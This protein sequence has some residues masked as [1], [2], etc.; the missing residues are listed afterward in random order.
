MTNQ[1]SAKTDQ[2]D[3]I[4]LACKL[5]SIPSVTPNSKDV[6]D[7]LTQHLQNLDFKVERMVFGDDSPDE[8]AVDNLFAMKGNGAKHLCFAGHVDVV[9]PGDSNLWQYPPFEA[10]IVDG[11]L[12]GRGACDM[13][14]AIAAFICAYQEILSTTPNAFDE[15]TI[16]F[17]ITGD[18]EG[19]G[20]NGTKKVLEHLQTQNIPIDFCIVGEPTGLKHSGDQIK[21]GRRGSFTATI[22][23]TGKQGHAAYPEDALNPIGSAN[24]LMSS[25]LSL[26]LGKQSELLNIGSNL[27]IVGIQSSTQV[28]N[29]IP[30]TIEILFNIRYNEHYNP[31]ILQ[32]MLEEVIEK[33]SCAVS[34]NL[35]IRESG[36]LPFL[37]SQNSTYLQLV[38]DACHKITGSNPIA[39]TTGGTSD[40]RYISKTSSCIELGTPNTS[41][42]QINEHV[43]TDELLTLLE[44]Y[45]EIIKKWLAS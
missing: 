15:H 36:S 12:F 35:N 21:I 24:S 18:E 1:C 44:I 29:I 20:V 37:G 30:E 9:P 26:D 2:N 40:A 23:V 5:I 8:Y 13:K 22:S 11:K 4:D 10:T 31:K 33:F 7:Y 16:S 27:E 28:S 25:L 38:V 41:A 6:L 19:I 42:H 14:A 43:F 34:I 39:S 32:Q 17:L 3:V 45:K